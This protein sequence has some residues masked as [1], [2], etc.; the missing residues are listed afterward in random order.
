[1]SRPGGNLTGITTL[2]GELGPKRLELLH[3]LVPSET[4]IALL[5]NPTN[6]SSEGASS[7]VQAAAYILGLQLHILKASTEREF[8][9]V[10]ASLTQLRAAGLVIAADPFFTGRSEQLAAIT[11]RW[12]ARCSQVRLP[13]SP[14]SLPRTP[15]NGPR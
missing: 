1:M 9:M 5:I 10:P 7:D 3:E 2:A 14:V 6:P 11:M 12:G 8:G 13:I 4:V 15:R